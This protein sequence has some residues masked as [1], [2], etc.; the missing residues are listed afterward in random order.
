MLSE[1]SAA[2]QQAGGT[3]SD[4]FDRGSFAN[5]FPTFVWYIAVQLIALATLPIGLLLFSRLPDRGYLLTKVL[6]LLFVGYLAWLLASLRILDFSPGG[7]W[8]MIVV[9]GAVSGLVAWRGR[10]GVVDFFRRRWRLI[11]FCEVLFLV[12]FLSFYGVRA[13]N[14]DLWHPWR[15]GEKPMDFAYLNAVTR[16][17]EMPPYDP[18][19]AGGHLNYYYFGQFQIASITKITGVLP[20]TAFNL[21]IAL[22]FALTVGGAFSV[23]YNLAASRGGGGDRAPPSIPGGPY[24]A[25]ITGAVFVAVIG[26]LDGAVQ[27]GQVVWR[28]TFGEGSGRAV[29]LLEEQPRHRHILPGRAQL[30][31]R[32]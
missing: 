19:F 32:L 23:V 31:R 27:M 4:L 16:S 28:F 13:W 22:V 20:S 7:L 12:A 25:G 8:L 10:V 1:G 15:G 14:P 17:T 29:R 6:G 18:W 2:R 11:L 21:A 9:V 30:L 5:R 26:N 3:F 24:L